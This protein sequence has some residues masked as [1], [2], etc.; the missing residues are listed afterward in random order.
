MPYLQVD[1]ISPKRSMVM[2]SVAD[3]N[4]SLTVRSGVV[5]KRTLSLL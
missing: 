5:L 1:E 2:L 4:A 3:R